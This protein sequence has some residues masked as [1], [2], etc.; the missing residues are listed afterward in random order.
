MSLTAKRE[1]WKAF[2][3]RRRPPN[4]R[5]DA[6]NAIIG[7]HAPTKSQG[8]QSHIAYYVFCQD[9]QMSPR[10]HNREGKYRGVEFS[11]LGPAA[12]QPMLKNECINRVHTEGKEESDC[13][14]LRKMRFAS[15]CVVPIS[16]ARGNGQDHQKF[17]GHSFQFGHVPL[18]ARS[19]AF[20]QD[21][22]LVLHRNQSPKPKKREETEKNPRRR[23]VGKDL[24]SRPKTKPCESLRDVHGLI[25][26]LPP[27]VWSGSSPPGKIKY[28]S[29]EQVTAGF[30]PVAKQN[31]L[32]DRGLNHCM[33]RGGRNRSASRRHRGGIIAFASIRLGTWGSPIESGKRFAVDTSRRHNKTLGQR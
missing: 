18:R 21:P 1:A 24:S 13:K 2:E 15:T 14:G 11:S 25:T 5:S 16:L 17:A 20:M 26:E 4:H 31:H 29:V 33:T 32:Q 22:D 12:L 7:V 28:E 10:G 8:N 6:Q 3:Q 19:A 30:V 9:K 27:L 23:K